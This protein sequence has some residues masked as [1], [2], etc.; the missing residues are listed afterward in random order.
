M[1]AV[2]PVL[3]GLVA[4]AGLALAYKALQRASG[5]ADAD[6]PCGDVKDPATA[7]PMK[8]SA[9]AIANAVNPENGTTN[10]GH[11]IDAVIARVK[12]TDPDAVAP[13]EQDGS[14]DEI[15][16]R[17]G[18]QLKWGQ[19]FEQ[20]FDQVNSGPEGTTAVVGIIYGGGAASH[21]V[22]ISKLNGQATIIEGQDWGAGNPREAITTPQRAN[23][24]YN[25]DGRSN[26]GVGVLP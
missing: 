20:A 11:I 2:F 7:C 4:T 17:H 23:E 14:F 25:P 6:F 21:V 9:T 16:K 1:A 18:T 8:Q 10:C 26:V 13:N 22:V 19:T 3:A 12:G 5:A 24:R 15:E